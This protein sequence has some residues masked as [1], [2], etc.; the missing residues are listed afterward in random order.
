MFL[1]LKVREKR[2]KLDLV[3]RCFL[4]L[5]E[6]PDRKLPWRQFSV[7]EDILAKFKELVVKLE[8]QILRTLEFDFE[9]RT[10]YQIFSFFYRK[11]KN[12]F[13][14]ESEGDELK[15]KFKKF[16]ENVMSFIGD[17]LRTPLCLLVPPHYIAAACLY[18]SCKYT[19]YELPVLRNAEGHQQPWNEAVPF[20]IPSST[21]HLVANMILESYPPHNPMRKLMTAMDDGVSLLLEEAV[22]NSEAI[23]RRLV[24]ARELKRIAAEKQAN[25]RAMYGGAPPSSS[26]QGNGGKRGASELED[27]SDGKRYRSDTSGPSGPTNNPNVSAAPVAP[28]I[29]RV[30]SGL[31]LA[32]MAY[33][34]VSRN[35]D[36]NSNH[37]NHSN[38]NNSNVSVSNNSYPHGHHSRHSYNN[39]NNNHRKGGDEMGNE[40]HAPARERGEHERSRSQ[41]PPPTSDRGRPAHN[42]Y[43]DERPR[44]GAAA[45]NAPLPWQHSRYQSN[46]RGTPR[47]REHDRPMNRNGPRVSGPYSRDGYHEREQPRDSYYH[48]TDRTDRS[49]RNDQRWNDYSHR[50]TNSGSGNRSSHDDG[51]PFRRERDERIGDR[52]YPSTGPSSS[53]ERPPMDERRDREHSRAM[54][55]YG[56]GHG[57]GSHGPTRPYHSNGGNGRYPPQRRSLDGGYYDDLDAKSHHYRRDDQS[58]QSKR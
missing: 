30:A 31:R 26:E 58:A 20:A 42:R 54:D 10:P 29:S 15:L 1:A 39:N 6:N 22:R 41:H 12:Y 13:H 35:D 44:D 17:S 45:S 5:Q 47:E 8:C 48:R 28:A 51:L 23:G 50:N 36:T 11:Y 27:R 46:G 2:R 7:N 25:E 24:A 34:A 56:N 32:T 19:N 53:H 38:S 40:R 14:D 43:Y 37:S 33:G 9:V 21:V 49:E 55:H 57:G 18:L 3:C 4:Y 52:L 16:S